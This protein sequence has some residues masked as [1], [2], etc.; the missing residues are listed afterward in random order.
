MTEFLERIRENAYFSSLPAGVQENVL[1]S[2]VMLE[3]EAE[4]RRFSEKLMEEK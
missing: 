1:Q 4:L 2:G 3:T